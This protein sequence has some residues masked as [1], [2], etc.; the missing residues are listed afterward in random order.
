LSSALWTYYG[1][2]KPGSILVATVNGFGVVVEIVFVTIFL[3]FAPPRTRV[4]YS[5]SL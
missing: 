4:S 1:I 2:T 3:V 5:S